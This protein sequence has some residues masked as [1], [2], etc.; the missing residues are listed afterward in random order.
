MNT[1]SSTAQLDQQLEEKIILVDTSDRQIGTAEKLQAHRDGLLHRAFSIFVLN[2]QGQLLLQRRAKHKYHSGGLWTN[3]CCSHPRDEEP[4]IL[5][6]HRRLQE[7]MGFDCELQELFSF[8]YW[9]ELDNDLIEYEFDH[10]FVGYS[11]REPILNPDEADDWQWIDLQVLQT[12]IRE[13]PEAYTYW[14]R[15]CCD[16]FIAALK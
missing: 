7:E 15:D 3:T 14:L 5:A 13:H 2:S 4:T 1:I 10:V 11:D 9:A 8:V 16:R 12:D 6:A